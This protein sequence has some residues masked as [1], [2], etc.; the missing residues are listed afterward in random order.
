[1][2]TASL[3][4]NKGAVLLLTVFGLT[5]FLI[6]AAM[7]LDITYFFLVRSEL[8]NIADNAALAA[9]GSFVESINNGLPRPAAI[10]AAVNAAKDIG[11]NSETFDDQGNPFIITAADISFGHYNT[12]THTFVATPNPFN[13]K[14]LVDAIRVTARKTGANPLYRFYYNFIRVK[15]GAK[16]MQESATASIVRKN[17]VFLMDIS[18]SMDDNTYMANYV[19][20]ALKKPNA[21]GIGPRPAEGFDYYQFQSYPQPSYVYNDAVRGSMTLGGVP[22]PMTSVLSTVRNFFA[23]SLPA[24]ISNNDNVGFFTFNTSVQNRVAQ[25]LP[26]N[27]FLNRSN[28]SLL[29]NSCQRSI[30]FYTQY[31]NDAMASSDTLFTYNPAR[32]TA[33]LSSFSPMNPAN[34]ITSIVDYKYPGGQLDRS[35]DRNYQFGSAMWILKNDPTIIFPGGAY[36]SGEDVNR[37]KDL[38]D[39]VDIQPTGYTNMGGVLRVTRIELN[40]ITSGGIPAFNMIILL[41]DGLPNIR[42]NWAGT[43]GTEYLD[44]RS[45]KYYAKRYASVQASALKNDNVRICTIFFQ[46][47]GANGESFLRNN[48]ASQPAAQYHYNASNA[49]TLA[50]I[51]NQILLTFPYV[52][53][54]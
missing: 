19:P 46:T 37:D 45:D 3:K 22:E 52:L 15:L 12:T 32:F 34:P 30:N 48:I 35:Q 9:M 8:Q 27:S 36:P 53:V 7:A 44:T 28:L 26:G 47:E 38:G 20:S 24:V 18:A 23:V 31:I 50:N 17:I 49:A 25:V 1:M 2:N 29:V 42:A 51:F 14:N 40:K 16:A 5:A 13:P 39:G 54:E 4:N 11:N 10:L 33:S 41:T 6:I 43:G 21:D